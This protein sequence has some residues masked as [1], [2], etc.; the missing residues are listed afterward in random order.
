MKNSALFLSCK[1]ET[2]SVAY[3]LRKEGIPLSYYLHDLAYA[4]SYKN[5]LPRTGL[6][7]L[8]TAI[9]RAEVIVVDTIVKNK[10]SHRDIA[11]LDKFGISHNVPDVYGRLVDLLRSPKWDKLVI[12][13]GEEMGQYELDRSK[14]FDSQRKP[15]SVSPPTRNLRA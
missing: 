11:L 1:G 8:V 13:P 14:G 12:G 15:D 3:E 9:K 2:L 6:D 5:I 10:K 4:G 7:D